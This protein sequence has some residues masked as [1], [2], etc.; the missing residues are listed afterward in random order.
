VNNQVLFNIYR[1]ETHSDAIIPVNSYHFK[2]HKFAAIR[3]YTKRAFNILDQPTVRN[4]ELKIIK[5]IGLNNGFTHNTVNKIT[6]K[7]S[8]TTSTNNPVNKTFSDKIINT[9]RKL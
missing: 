6:Q 7:S 3:T 8:T 5:Q 2:P 4:T 9:F 1:K